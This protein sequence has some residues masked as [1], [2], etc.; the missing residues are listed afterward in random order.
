MVVWWGCISKR[1][2]GR[3]GVG[4]TDEQFL[5]DKPLLIR[6]GKMC[7]TGSSNLYFKFFRGTAK[8]FVIK[9]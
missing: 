8:G 5:S 6:C 3:G 1:G 7:S 2:R 9:R 4:D